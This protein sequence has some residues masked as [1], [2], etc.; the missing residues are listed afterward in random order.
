MR[1][2]HN[3]DIDLAFYNDRVKEVIDADAIAEPFTY[4]PILAGH[5]E[6][7]GGNA[8]VFGKIMEGYDIISP[9]IEKEITYVDVSAE[10]PITNL[11][12]TYWLTRPIEIEYWNTPAPG[13]FPAQPY[14]T[15]KDFWDGTIS[16][17]KPQG[18]VVIS[19]PAVLEVLSIFYIVIYNPAEGINITA[20]YTVLPGDTYAD[21]KTG[22]EADLI[23]NGMNPLDIEV[24][25]FEQQIALYGGRTRYFDRTPTAEAIDM[26]LVYENFT[27]TAYILNVGKT[28]KYP[29]LK[30]GATHGY[31]IVYKDRSGRTCS[32]LKTD[33]MTIYVPFYSEHDDNDLQTIVDLKFKIYHAPPPWAETHEIVYY[34]N[35][36]MDYFFQVRA[37]NIT[38]IPDS[39]D[40]RYSINIIETLYW[41][42]SQNNRWRVASY[43]WE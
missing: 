32:V 3:T 23:A 27:F 22:L 2:A 40:N 34:G 8:I 33:D 10:H 9:S 11:N 41:A 7:V 29:Q 21:V 38:L 6:L 39:N 24:W 28:I 18:A 20:S 30:V 26:S 1:G 31:G 42:W 37:N 13:D 5:L 16:Y 36:S 17:Y 43:S 12:V 19:I 25:P 35:L 4:V 15:E 14:I